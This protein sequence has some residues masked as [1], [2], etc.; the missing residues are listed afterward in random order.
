MHQVGQGGSRKGTEA[1]LIPYNSQDK[2]GVEY[3]GSKSA[4]HHGLIG[5]TIQ[6]ERS[7]LYKKGGIQPYS[8]FC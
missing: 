1:I 6:W 7:Y 4:K 5:R 2:T 3:N 8:N